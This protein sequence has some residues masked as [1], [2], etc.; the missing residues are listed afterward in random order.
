MNAV[1]HFGGLCE[2]GPRVWSSE[3]W[4]S[5]R[6]LFLIL[7]LGLVARLAMLLLYLST[8][9]WK[10]ETWEYE[11]IAQNLLEG[12]GFT[13]LHHNTVYRSYIVPVFPLICAFLHRIGGPGLG[14][15][16]AFHL[17]IAVGIIW[18]TYTIA[19]R[20]YGVRAATLAAVLTAFEPGLIVYHSYKV[21]VITLSTFILLLGI[22]FFLLMDGS[23]DKRLA[24]LVGL[25]AG[26]GVLTRPDLI[27]L[28]FV[29][30]A[31]LVVE[32][33][34]LG[35]AYRLAALIFLTAIVI[36]MPWFVRNYSVHDKVV[37]LATISGESLW[38]GN[39]PN[40]TGTTVTQDIRGQF[41]AAPEEFRKKVLSLSE[42]EQ[43][44][45][46]REEAVKY[47]AADPR[48]FLRRAFEKIYYFWWFTP[49]FARQYYDWI[50][51]P[52]VAAYRIFYGAMLALA[53][54][55]I[56]SVMRSPGTDVTRVT[57]Y[58]F[59]LPIAMAIIH[60]VN[61][62]EGRHRVLVMPVIMIL[63]AHGVTVLSKLGS[64]KAE[65]ADLF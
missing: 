7:G 53:M 8:H 2:T 17:S 46:F 37:L 24:V 29:P 45:F 42:V 59:V 20:W 13:F 22:H 49:T 34:R 44:T 38:R 56:W 16:Y 28:F 15:Y 1:S 65:Q 32:R 10:G 57:L 58:L 9:D 41:D 39:N 63:T 19:S 48:R 52:F 26:I 60:S 43:D 54:L 21:D 61:Y 18:L 11:V 51:L 12:R 30:V 6:V 40:A 35:E 14:L 36:M 31:W 47:I 4:Q 33:R 3:Y 62:V 55:G 27:G 25:I 50:P 23:W 5:H 64:S